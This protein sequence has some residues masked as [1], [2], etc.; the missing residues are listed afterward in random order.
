MFS[1]FWTERVF[2]AQ[3]RHVLRAGAST[4][5]LLCL[6]YP[7]LAASPSAA[8]DRRNP[9][10]NLRA[11]M[12]IYS[13]IEGHADI[14]SRFD[15][16]IFAVIGGWG[17]LIPLLGFEGFA[18]NRTV[19]QDDGSFR[20]FIN[21]VAFYKD[22]QTGRIIDAWDNPF[23]NERVEVFQLHA[24]PLT[25]RLG[26][27]RRFERPD[28]TFAERP[29]VLPW[30]VLEDDAFISIEFN[31]VR[32]NPLQPD[33][34]PRE[35]VGEKIR[36]SESMQFMTR[37]SVLEDPNVTRVYPNMAWTLL[38]SWLPWMLMGRHEG[39]LLYRNVVQKVTSI[40]GVP[41]HI[42]DETERRFPQYL[43]AP[44]DEAWGAFRTSDKVFKDEREPQSAKPGPQETVR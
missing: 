3:R 17:A 27:V 33:E 37:M 6:D 4:A 11:W 14:Y 1:R 12:K 7:L 24:G 16:H 30:F 38:R 13:D 44:P 43:A 34:W 25:S 2:D 40:D 29:F 21:E 22:P 18:V 28:G 36:V 10:D 15:G 26:T 32:D 9:E 8:L 5:G 42:L 23:T 39:H 31:D 41:R 35:S 20:V 19:P